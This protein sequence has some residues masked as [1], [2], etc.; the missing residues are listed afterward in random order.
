MFATTSDAMVHKNFQEGIPEMSYPQLILVQV[1][2]NLVNYSLYQ[3]IY[4]STQ[5][6]F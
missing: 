1:H 2:K 5:V 3:L 4:P 6:K